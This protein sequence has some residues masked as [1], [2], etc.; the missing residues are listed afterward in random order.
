M[1]VSRATVVQSLSIALIVFVMLTFV[2]AV[3]TYLFFTRAIGLEADT[4]KAL[5][6]MAKANAAQTAAE[7]E[8]DALK[9]AI[10]LAEG[11]EK[12]GDDLKADLGERF[13]DVAEEKRHYEGVV[14]AL[15]DSLKKVSDDLKKAE[16]VAAEAEKA[17][18]EAIEAAKVKQKELEDEVTGKGTAAEKLKQQFDADRAKHEELTKELVEK[19]KDALERAERL[20]LLVAE[21]GKGE[22]LL[23]SARQARFKAQEAEG[24][25]GLLFDELRD[26]EKQILRQNEVLA[27]LR[28]ADKS[29]Q[30]TVLAA[31]PKD[32]RIDGFDG[33]VLSVNEADRS[34][35]ID[36]GATQGLR[37]GLVFRVYAP[38]EDQPQVSDDKAMVEVV[39]IE[40]DAL[41]RARIRRESIRNPIL[42]GDRV[43]T[44]LW[45]PRTPF[46]A[47]IVG[48]PQLDAD[49]KPDQDRLQEIVERVGG[50]V[51][52]LVTS[53]TTMLVDA[54]PPRVGAGGTERAAVWRP[55]DET[56]RDRQLKEARRL[57]IQIVGL[58]AFLDMLGLDRESLDS[59][60]LIHV[61]GA[62][63][64]P[65]AAGLVE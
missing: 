17:R 22:S 16:D 40:G 8:R 19:Q 65:T 49:Q 26:R 33:R 57:G 24:R 23:P 48:F 15:Q 56:R 7:G 59:N 45:K 50:R 55:A 10:G 20:D 62:A 21:I 47:V 60:R 2:L 38:G 25:I 12:T 43:A 39:A 3:T 4:E 31:T 36:V 54:G 6:D 53:S 42:R 44:S 29:L 41:A 58:D 51:E 13:G 64:S 30:E 46:E 9:A 61:G 63:N 37:P 35:L 52:Q 14:A 11:E 32:D 1:A 5:D 18:Q 34:V 27:A 28:V